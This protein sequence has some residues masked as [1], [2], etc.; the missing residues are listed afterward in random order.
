MELTRRSLFGLFAAAPAV[1]AIAS[2]VPKGLPEVPV[3]QIPASDL[4]GGLVFLKAD[5]IVERSMQL[6]AMLAPGQSAPCAYLEHGR[7]TLRTICLATPLDGSKF[8]YPE[9]EC[10]ENGD[11]SIGYPAYYHPVIEWRLA[12]A[13]APVYGQMKSFSEAVE[14][15]RKIT[16]RSPFESWSPPSSHA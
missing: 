14:Y 7:Q 13:L 11:V 9:F 2:S 12:L 15:H 5:E 10:A 3:V 4:E 1:A 6:L 8:F 16:G